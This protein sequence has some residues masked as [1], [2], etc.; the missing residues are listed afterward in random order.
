M[1][2]HLSEVLSGPFFFYL[3]GAFT[4]PQ[5]AYYFSLNDTNDGGSKYSLP[6]SGDYWK[7]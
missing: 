1:I 3:E 7:V 4:N 6:S 2:V 5:S